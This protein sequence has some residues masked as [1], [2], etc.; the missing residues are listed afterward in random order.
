MRVFIAVELP[1]KTKECLNRIQKQLRATGADVKWV[2]P[3][4]IHLTLKFLGEI[5]DATLD[6]VRR[7][8][9]GVAADKAI[10]YA[11]LSCIGAFPKI[12]YPRV[13]WTGIDKGDTEIKS[14]AKEL[15]E[16]LA[17]IGIPA[18]DREFS[19]H[20]TIGRL[21]SGLNKIRL[22]REL[23]TL[24]EN[25]WQENDELE[26]RVS[27]LTLFKSTLT[28]KGPVYEALKEAS[29]KKP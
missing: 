28:P 15:D 23:E 25:P 7:I 6:N 3:A 20:I 9:D 8:L 12:S 24:K 11:R 10:F 27:A 18:Q 16:R 4:N 5:E 2:E 21:R 17:A 29:L 1:P 19:S 26:F 13:I 22:I 14:I